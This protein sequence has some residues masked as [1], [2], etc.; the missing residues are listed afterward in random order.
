M[1]ERA[2]AQQLEAELAGF[3]AGPTA[4]DTVVRMR[5]ESCLHQQLTVGQPRT[6][7]AVDRQLPRQLY[8]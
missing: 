8:V 3:P 6:V 5:A 2:E 1:L 4:E 7:R